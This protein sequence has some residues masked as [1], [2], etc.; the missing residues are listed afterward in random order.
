MSDLETEIE[1]RARL[2]QRLT[3]ELGPMD[4]Q[5]VGGLLGLF[6]GLSAGGRSMLIEDGGKQVTLSAPDGQRIVFAGSNLAHCLCGMLQGPEGL[7]GE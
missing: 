5:T 6:E 2:L 3:A 1:F 4:G 7:G